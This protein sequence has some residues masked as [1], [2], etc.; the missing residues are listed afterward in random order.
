MQR[1]LTTDGVLRQIGAR[2]RQG[3][4]CSRE[5]VAYSLRVRDSRL[6]QHLTPPPLPSSHKKTC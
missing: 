4:G 6:F 5:G 3:V 2:M 1:Y